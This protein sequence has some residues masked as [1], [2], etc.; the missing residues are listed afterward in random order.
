MLWSCRLKITIRFCSTISPIS[1]ELSGILLLINM[2]LVVVEIADQLYCSYCFRAS[3]CLN[4]IKG[5]HS[6][7][8]SREVLVSVYCLFRLVE[9]WLCHVPLDRCG[10]WFFILICWDVVYV[11]MTFFVPSVSESYSLY[12]LCGNGFAYPY[13]HVYKPLLDGSDLQLYC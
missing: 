5:A 9:K 8:D 3:M 4:E 13:A 10:G 7:L 1:F 11:N 2:N 12:I 6:F